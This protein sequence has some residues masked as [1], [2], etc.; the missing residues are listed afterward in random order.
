MALATEPVAELGLQEQTPTRRKLGF[1]QIGVASGQLASGVGNLAFALVTARLLDPSG[2]AHLSVFLGFYLV[3]SLPATSLSAATAIDPARRN[4][5]QRRMVVGSLFLAACVAGCAPLLSTALNLPT[6]MVL[7][8]AAAIPAIPP[9]SVERGR[10]YGTRRHGRLV[11]S[12]AAEPAVR[13]SAGVALAAGTGQVGAAVAVVLGAYAAWRVAGHTPTWRHIPRM[14]GTGET[15]AAGWTALSF[16]LLA[17]LQTQDLVF[18]NVVLPS[19]QA[20][21]YA[22]LSTLGGAAAFATATIPFVLLPRVVRKDAGSLAVAT[23]VAAALGLAAVGVGAVAPRALSAAL[24]GPRYGSI[25]GYVVL[26]LAAMGLLGVGRVLVAYRSATA[27]SASVVVTVAVVAGCQAAAIALWGRSVGTIAAT[28]VGATAALVS[29]VALEPFMVRAM[30]RVKAGVTR[31]AADRTI[32]TVVAVTLGGLALR[33]VVIRGIW[34]DEA[35]SIHQASMSFGAMISNLR[36]TDVHPP[37]Y[38]SVLWMTE[39]LLGNGS[40]A[41]RIPSILA[42]ALAI[43]AAYLAARDLW[44][45]RSGVVAAVI[46]AVAPLLVWYSQE[47]RMYSMF[48]LEALIA[49]WGQARVLRYGRNRDWAL[50]VL[51]SVALVWTEYFGLLQVITQLLVFAAVALTRR[52]DGGRRLLVGLLASAAMIA[53]LCIPLVSFVWHQFVVNQNA[54]KGFGTPS[55]VGLPGQASISVYRVLANIAWMLVGYHSASIMTA[56][57]A[58]WPAGMLLALFLLGRNMI[59]RTVAVVATAMVPT[60]ILIGIGFSKENLFDVRYISGASVAM[61]L[62]LARGL[63]GAFG[64]VRFQA[65]GCALIACLM[66]VSLGDEQLNGSNPRAFDFSG[67]LHYVQAQYRPG[68]LLVYTPGDLGLVV[69]Y[70][71]ADIPSEPLTSV[72]PAVGAGSKIFVLGSKQLMGAGQPAQLGT[73]VSR[74]GKRDRLIGDIAKANVTVWVFRS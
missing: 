24:F 66:I 4:S 63:T 14:T 31:A 41:I 32:R 8:L 47:A 19:R 6:L 74:L 37:L 46:T 3:L 39:H 22:A 49:I 33:F 36:D 23:A 70:Y 43:P 28:T 56:I 7:G 9:L 20:A 26:Y 11:A 17:L 35:T 29:G 5:I 42:G 1:E 15:P 12:L 34:L 71:A 13:L 60:L 64:S 27:S 59:D 62:L 73:T 30:T 58:L 48:M 18:A 16:L 2:F 69:S 52:G 10:L 51:P 68:D 57:V 65:L 67:A 54:G 38:Y 45:K 40:L 25:A 61:V 53:A 50:F 72:V 21:A 44:D 55:Q